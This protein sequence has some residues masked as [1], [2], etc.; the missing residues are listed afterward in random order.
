[1]KSNIYVDLL[2][3]VGSIIIAISTIALAIDTPKSGGIGIF[4]FLWGML[5]VLRAAL[6]S[7]RQH[8]KATLEEYENDRT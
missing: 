4:L 8:L 7:Y 2:L 5:W 6:E 1:M 3:G